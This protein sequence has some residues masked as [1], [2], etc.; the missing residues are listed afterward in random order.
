MRGA[1]YRFVCT[2][3]RS[4]TVAVVLLGMLSGPV[5]AEQAGPIAAEASL[6][7]PTAALNDTQSEVAPPL[8]A[9]AVNEAQFAQVPADIVS[10]TVLKTQILL[11]RAHFSV[12][13]IDGK[14]GDNFRKA[15]AAFQSD[16]GLDA[17]GTLDAP[18]WDKLVATSNDAVLT[19]YEITAADLKGPFNSNIPKDWEE[20]AKLPRLDYSGLREALA[21]RFHMQEEL[22]TALNPGVSF[23]SARTRVVVANV[24]SDNEEG[25]GNGGKRAGEPRVTR[26]EIDK[27][28]RS[29]RAFDRTGKLVAF[30]PA[31]IGSAE[32]P[33]PRGTF[34]V[35][36]VL[37]NPTY[38]Y[39]P[40]FAF[41][42]V[43]T[44]KKFSIQGGP[45]NPVGVAWIDL[46]VPS[47]GIHGTPEPENVG[48]T[49]SH[50]CVRL[51]NWDVLALAALVDRGTVV[52]LKE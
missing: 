47:Y 48:H 31:S 7:V 2:T 39:D 22:L 15:L 17:S 30:Y 21:E 52:Q 24:R 38:Q 26:I 8:T 5:R 43:K 49:G 16:K 50:G 18:T 14:S 1:E 9:Q 37:I 25:G 28:E 40:K 46:S 13:A 20:M 10:A 41:P 6:I 36:N 33:T 19:N 27:P 12:G 11:D 32:K 23:D 51:T 42:E 29:L 4:V 35:Q 44:Q 45:N 3:N 34:K